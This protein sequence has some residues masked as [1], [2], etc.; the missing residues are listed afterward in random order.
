[1][2][3]GV[4]WLIVTFALLLVLTHWIA[5]HVQGIGYLLTEDGQIAMTVYLLLTLPGVLLHEC[6][7][8][9]TAILLRVKVRRFS[10][11]IRR[12]GQDLVALGS[13]DIAR[14][15]PIRAS[16]IGLAPL[17]AGCAVILLIGSQ[18]LGFGRFEPFSP[19]AFWRE[20]SGMYRAPDFWLWAYLVLAVGNTMFPSAADRHAWWLALIFIAFVGAILY[21]AGLLD[22]LSTAV[23]GWAQ[24]AMNLLTYA[25]AVTVIVDLVFGVF[26]F[27]VERSLGI[28]GFGR[29]KYQ[30][31]WR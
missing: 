25:F 9:L 20:L 17:A 28:L 14:T 30:N 21:F 5:R 16:L 12:K 19:G 11:G 2:N 27:L 3:D 6:S 7:H 18:A 1:M 22:D 4:I 13:V 24:G 8:A 15:D 29:I 10:I 26:L 23:G 31:K